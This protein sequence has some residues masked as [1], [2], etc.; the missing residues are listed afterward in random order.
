MPLLEANVPMPSLVVDKKE[1]DDKSEEL[2]N[3][4]NVNILANNALL[5][6]MGPMSSSYGT[7]SGDFSFDQVTVYVV[8]QGDTI[9][10][11]ADM[12]DVSVDTILSANDLKKGD[13]LKEGDALLI[14][15]FSGV[16]HTVSKGQTLKGIANLYKVDVGDI[17]SFNDIDSDTKLSIGDKLMI[18]GASI[19]NEPKPRSTNIAKNSGRIP[20][21]NSSIK[22]ADGYF[23][24]PVPKA[25]KTR[26]TSSG[27]KGVDLAAPTGT[28]IYTAAA[29]TVIFARLGYNGGFGNMVMVSHP[30]GTR[31]LYAHM[32]RLGTKVGAQVAQGDVIGYVGSTGHSTGPHLHFEVQGARNP[33]DN[34]SWKY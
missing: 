19:L 15:P 33:G 29:G 31:T 11:I 30:N 1:K 13:K 8:R 21:Y 25:R 12:F 32:S 17:L 2:K 28:P 16:E 34:W 26:G 18:P 5:P 9:A 23:S 24:N 3:D 10:Q 14:L 7:G 6:S 27:H 22:N 4:I 20:S